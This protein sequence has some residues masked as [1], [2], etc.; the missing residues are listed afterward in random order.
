M[1]VH[2]VQQTLHSNMYWDSPVSLI[3]KHNC[4]T[5]IVFPF[6]AIFTHS[7]LMSSRGSVRKGEMIL[8][9]GGVVPPKAGESNLLRQDDVY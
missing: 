3:Y 4:T 5:V 6:V 7:Y 8:S 2:L 1:Y 9:D